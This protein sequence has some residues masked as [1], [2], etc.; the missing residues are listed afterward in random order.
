MHFHTFILK[1]DQNLLEREKKNKVWK[2][3][4]ELDAQQ[5]A[6]FCKLDFLQSRILTLGCSKLKKREKNPALAAAAAAAEKSFL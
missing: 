5:P 4:N 6:L 2:V 1:E 3:R